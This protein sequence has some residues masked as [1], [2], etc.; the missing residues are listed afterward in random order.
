MTKRFALVNIRDVNFH[1][2]NGHSRQRIAQGHAGMGQATRI[3]DDRIHALGF[4]GMYTVDQRSVMIA[5][6][7]RQGR[8]GSGSLG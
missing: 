7:A 2:R 5:V 4:G 1:E 3:D 6:K 8:A